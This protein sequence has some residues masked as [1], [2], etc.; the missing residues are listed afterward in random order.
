[1]TIDDKLRT[2]MLAFAQYSSSAK[3]IHNMIA[4]ARSELAINPDQLDRD[5]W[6][7][8]VANGTIELRTGQLR[9]HRR[10]DFLT[11]L[12]PVHFDP[13]APCPKWL[14][15]VDKV[16]GH[17]AELIAY[18]QRL[19]GYALTGVTD[20]HVLPFLWGT[21][22]NG[23]STFVETV[24]DLL[25][26]DYAMK[27]P[28]DLLMAKR[29][30]SHPTERADLFGKRFVA[31]VETEEGRR[32]AEVLVKE[33]T[34]GDRIRAR[35]MREDFWQFVP[36]HHVWLVSNHKP[37]VIGADEGIWRRIKLVPFTQHFWNPD[38]PARPGEQRFMVMRQDKRLKHKLRA[39]LPAILN[40]ALKGCLDWQKDGMRE[41]ACVHAATTQYSD[42]M[43]L[44]G[45]FLDGH[46]LVG[47]GL[48]AAAGELHQAFQEATGSRM[49]P[50][51]FA[52]RLR[53]RGFG[54]RD[55]ST[56]K[57]Y[58]TTKGLHAWRGLQLRSEAQREGDLAQA[59]EARAA[60]EALKAARGRERGGG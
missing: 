20:E 32:L 44:L 12:A 11:K 6:L 9:E 16:F 57:H 17:D 56:G 23:K 39:E 14:A 19:T 26:P 5:S 47:E 48:L 58:R 2:A 22:A 60:V 50:Y 36:T 25:G 28:T 3:G 51:A 18:V 38:V 15:F 27:A 40:W 10:E 55:P 53:Q 24:M 59:R 52:E 49:S 37:I 31:C 13:A 33:L 35:R 54:D 1:M 41:P 42:E 8:N 29:G 45:P 7:F 34:G 43:D 30:E 21:G 46:C 4:M